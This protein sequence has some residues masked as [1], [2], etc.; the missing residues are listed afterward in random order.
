[1]IHLR[2][3]LSLSTVFGTSNFPAISICDSDSNMHMPQES[4]HE[5]VILGDWQQRTNGTASCGLQ[6]TSIICFA[7]DDMLLCIAD[8]MS[9]HKKSLHCDLDSFP[10]EADSARAILSVLFRS[11]GSRD[12]PRHLVAISAADLHLAAALDKGRWRKFSP[13][14]HLT[15]LHPIKRSRTIK[16]IK[17]YQVIERVVRWR[18]R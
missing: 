1:M 12:F 13:P 11:C 9:R 8:L 14:L 7:A 16:R 2:T 10:T 4:S 17:P 5:R 15:D 3:I 18:R 6:V